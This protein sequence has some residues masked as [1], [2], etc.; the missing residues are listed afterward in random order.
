MVP[1]T[2]KESIL[3]CIGDSLA[4]LLNDVALQIESI[5]INENPK[6]VSD[7]DW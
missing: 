1:I 2:V 3:L 7:L 4:K 6:K 5:V